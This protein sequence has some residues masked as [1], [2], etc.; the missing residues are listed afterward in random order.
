MAAPG[1]APAG[2][3]AAP[4]GPDAVF[5]TPATPV[6]EVRAP[7][8]AALQAAVS[9]GWDGSGGNPHVFGFAVVDGAFDDEYFK[10]LFDSGIPIAGRVGAKV[11]SPWSGGGEFVADSNTEDPVDASARVAATPARQ[12]WLSRADAALQ[13]AMQKGLISLAEWLVDSRGADPVRMELLYAAMQAPFPLFRDSAIPFLEARGALDWSNVPPSI[14]RSAFLATQSRDMFEF[15]LTKLPGG[16]FDAAMATE[17]A[18]DFAKGY[19]EKL[20]MYLIEHHSADPAALN[21]RFAALAASGG[22]DVDE[23]PQFPLVAGRQGM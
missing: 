1:N 11:L 7:M 18:F 19:N 22:C 10:L 20:A 15:I 21:E 16:M 14:A 9:A 6:Y 12:G 13:Y 17:L 2:N 23:Y 3:P 4:A 8:P 5:L